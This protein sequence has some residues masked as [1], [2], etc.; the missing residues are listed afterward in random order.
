MKFIR[1]FEAIQYDGT[2]KK[3]IEQML[4]QK[5]Q[6]VKCTLYEGDIT[7]LL[8]TCPIHGHHPDVYNGDWIVKESDGVLS[9][10]RDKDFRKKFKK[11]EN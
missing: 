8:I 2:N 6:R 9:S 11:V 5:V 7:K 10:Y 4:G 1:E 3:E